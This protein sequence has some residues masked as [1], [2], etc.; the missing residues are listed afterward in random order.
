MEE[1][2]GRQAG[3]AVACSDDGSPVFDAGLMRQAL[4]YASMLDLP[5]INH[6][7]NLE[8]NPNGQMHEG[9]VA[10]RL[11]LPGIPCLAEEVMIARDILISEVTGG[12]IHVAHISTAR[13]VKLVREAKKNGTK[14][15]SEVCTHH[16]TLT[17]DEIEKNPYNTHLKMHPPPRPPNAVEAMKGSLR[18]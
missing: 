6:M 8:L 9:A 11:G 13:G 18:E 12:S 16:F 17:A 5:V 1:L 3:D 2:A 4:E 14:V 10:T 7:E 15:T